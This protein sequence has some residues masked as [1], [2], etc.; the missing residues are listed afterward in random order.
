MTAE[1]YLWPR[2]VAVSSCHAVIAKFCLV[3]LGKGG[4]RTLAPVPNTTHII[5]GC[6]AGSVQGYA[7]PGVLYCECPA[8]DEILPA[9]PGPSYDII[10]DLSVNTPRRLQ[11]VPQPIR[12][13]SGERIRWRALLSA[14][15]HTD[16]EPACAPFQSIHHIQS[17]LA[18]SCIVS[19]VVDNARRRL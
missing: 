16:S 19:P 12:S 17:H 3:S 9:I 11:Q 10:T 18:C 1:V 7:A 13:P 4:A 5:T 15:D 2:A 6:S 14:P 8:C